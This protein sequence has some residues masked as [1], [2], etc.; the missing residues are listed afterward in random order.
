MMQVKDEQAQEEQQDAISAAMPLDAAAD[1]QEALDLV[2]ALWNDAAHAMRLDVAVIDV[3]AD[4]MVNSGLAGTLAAEVKKIASHASGEAAAQKHI[5]D[6]IL[7]HQHRMLQQMQQ[8]IDVQDI[9]P[10]DMAVNMPVN[11][12]DAFAALY[13]GDAVDADDASVAVVIDDVVIDDVAV[14]EVEVDE[15]IAHDVSGDDFVSEDV[16]DAVLDD[17]AAEIAIS[18]SHDDV[19]PA[20]VI[21]VAVSHVVMDVVSDVVV[22]QDDVNPADMAVAHDIAVSAVVDVPPVMHVEVSHV[23][24]HA[25]PVS[26]QPVVT[27]YVLDVSD[28]IKPVQIDVAVPVVADEASL[29]IIADQVM[30]E[31]DS[32]VAQPVMID[33]AF[34]VNENDVVQPVFVAD[35]VAPV[36]VQHVQVKDV[37][38][39]PKAPDMGAVAVDG[40]A[41]M[42]QPDAQPSV[43]VALDIA[44]DMSVASDAAPMVI[45]PQ[46]DIAFAPVDLP[47]ID[48][49][50]AEMPS[51][52][53][54][55]AVKEILSVNIS[56]AVADM[57]RVVPINNAPHV[58]IVASVDVVKEKPSHLSFTEGK[59]IV[60]K[61][62]NNQV[63][64]QASAPLRDNAKDMMTP[65]DVFSYRESPA[66][67]VDGQEDW[68]SNALQAQISSF[69]S[70]SA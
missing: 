10:M 42:P 4:E 5:K 56:D 29:P 49:P 32:V 43:Q 58:D 8:E 51:I 23:I 36:L 48:V 63:Q 3:L 20:V 46:N 47:L 11:G 13:D 69:Y 40:N 44:A 39:Q 27:S 28:A 64:S 22:A 26:K 34:V 70:Y 31:P 25:A 30:S 50:V 67:S 66:V 65:P 21:P 15:I 24:H 68:Y 37:M 18:Q 33:A 45:L 12:Y 14:D 62:D 52:P 38:P 16:L 35:M 59:V 7:F 61:P 2:T 6:L 57:E 17:V 1:Q 41:D 9:F 19:I 60:M 53:M 55:G 54:S